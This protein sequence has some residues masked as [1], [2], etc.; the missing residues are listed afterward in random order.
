M[1][2][3]G[4]GGGGRGVIA[5]KAQMG[6]KTDTGG[7][8]AAG[9]DQQH[10]VPDTYIRGCLSPMSRSTNLWLPSY[11]LFFFLFLFFLFFF[12]FFFTFL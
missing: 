7:C 11:S 3:D 4:E 8:E 12:L 1:C 5:G 10:P 6:G 9:R 2:A